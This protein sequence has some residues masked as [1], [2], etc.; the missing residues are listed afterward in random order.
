MAESVDATDL[1]V[2]LHSFL[3][4][5]RETFKVNAFKFR[6]TVFLIYEKKIKNGNPEPN[7]IISKGAETRR[8]L[9]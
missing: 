2:Q 1:K 4:L 7:R 8:K 6:E 9:P 5:Y 3:S